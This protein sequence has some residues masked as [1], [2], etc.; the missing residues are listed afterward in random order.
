M[1]SEAKIQQEIFVWH[2]NNR[3]HE[4]KLLFMVHNEASS[5][6]RGARLKGQGM[7]SGVSDLI[8]CDPRSNEPVFLEIKNDKGVQSNSQKEFENAV[9]FHGFKYYVVR[10]VEEAK[11][12]CRWDD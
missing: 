8:Y 2:W 9:A 12:V 3:P 10:S 11:E 4:R 7:V 1:K 6:I 5:R